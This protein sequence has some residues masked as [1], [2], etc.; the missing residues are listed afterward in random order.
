MKKLYRLEEGKKIAGICNGIADMYNFDV[1]LVRLAF[2]FVTVITQ[3]VPG[4]VTYLIGWYLIPE[5]SEVV[6]TD[7]KEG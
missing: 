7:V 2:V 3:F 4:I 5:K 1:T 6:K